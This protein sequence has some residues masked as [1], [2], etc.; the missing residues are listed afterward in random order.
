M[1]MN[2]IGKN[3]WLILFGLGILGIVFGLQFTFLSTPDAQ[4]VESLTGMTWE[5]IQ[6]SN[7]GMANLVKLGF[8]ALGIEILGFSL[9][10]LVLVWFGYRKDVKWT[11]YAS[12]TL[13]IT[14]LGFTITNSRVGGGEWPRFIALI[15]VALFGLILPFRRFFPSK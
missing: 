8:R 10:S 4:A 7:P 15:I 5:E 3:A 6:T 1:S 13:P 11:W 12:W 14:L 9:L 2:T